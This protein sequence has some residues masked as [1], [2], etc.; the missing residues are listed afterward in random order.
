MTL[1]HIV[2]L[3]VLFFLLTFREMVKQGEQHLAESQV[4]EQVRQTAVPA[5]SP[6]D[7]QEDQKIGQALEEEARRFTEQRKLQVAMAKKQ[8]DNMFK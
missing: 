8:L 5:E 6:A 4:H 2:F 3:A 7:T 1:E